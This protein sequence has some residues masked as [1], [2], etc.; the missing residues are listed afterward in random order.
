VVIDPPAYTRLIV[1]FPI[2]FILAAIGLD[3][4]LRR[5][6]WRFSWGGAELA[7]I[8]V[9][10]FAQ[11]AAFDLGGYYRFT[12]KMEIVPREWDVLSV[13]NRLDANYDVYL[14]TGPFLFAD[15]PVLRLFSTGVHAVSAFS[16]DDLPALLA[17]DAVFIVM[18]EYR[19]IGYLINDQFPGVE[20]D[21][22]EEQG[23]LKA[24]VYRCTY[25]NGCRR[26]IG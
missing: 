11:S 14:F 12:Q 7:L 25:D 19:R 6:Q 15:S 2:P 18:P 20:R 22:V 3:A 26:S 13:L 24:W 10:V 1:I 23:V 17:R 5:L 8:Y 21:A 16:E 9:L 4:M